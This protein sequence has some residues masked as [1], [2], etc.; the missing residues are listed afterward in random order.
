MYGYTGNAF[1]VT[2]HP[3]VEKSY[4]GAALT[5]GYHSHYVLTRKDGYPSPKI[6]HKSQGEDYYDELVIEQE[7]AILP[8]YLLKISKNNLGTLALAFQKDQE[9]LRKEAD[10]LSLLPDGRQKTTNDKKDDNQKTDEELY[11]LKTD[12]STSS[13]SD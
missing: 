2:E 6:L 5:P 7:A 12:S 1:P 8:Y 4:M 10:G 3:K 13:S 9:L 11:E